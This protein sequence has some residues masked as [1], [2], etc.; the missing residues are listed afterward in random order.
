MSDEENAFIEEQIPAT[1]FLTDEDCDLAAV[2]TNKDDWI[3]KPTDNYGAADVYAGK[4][5]SE[6]EWNALIDRFANG[7]AGAPFLVA[8]LRYALSYEDDPSCRRPRMA[9]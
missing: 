9:R 7:A 6:E 5:C 3:I 8:T 1:Y 4:A 2:R